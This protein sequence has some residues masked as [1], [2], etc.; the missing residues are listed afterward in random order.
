MVERSIILKDAYNHVVAGDEKLKKM[1]YINE[2][3]KYWVTLND[4]LEIF[5]ATALFL[6]SQR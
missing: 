4:Y 1:C 2:E 6:C 5:Y 3:F